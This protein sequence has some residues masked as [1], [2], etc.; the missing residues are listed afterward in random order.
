MR[1][2]LELTQALGYWGELGNS[3]IFPTL[4]LPHAFGDPLAPRLDLISRALGLCHKGQGWMVRRDALGYVGAVR[5]PEITDG[6]NGW[7]A[8]LHAL[9]FVQGAVS[10]SVV[11]SYRDWLYGRWGHVVASAG[12]GEINAYGL[13]VKVTGRDTG[14]IGE[15][16]QAVEG[17]WGMG[18]E[19][20]QAAAKYS[21]TPVD[22]LRLLAQTGDLS[23]RARWLEAEAATKGKSSIRYSKGLRALV[24]PEVEELS[25][26]EAASA[27]GLGR[28]LVKAWIERE[29]WVLLLKSGESGEALRELVEAAF[30]LVL[31]CELA[32]HVPAEVG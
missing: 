31:M 27:E 26:V 30:V 1:R 9:L 14:R 32:G 20:T 16:M 2:S 4:T 18:A 21:R 15:Y 12:F 6:P 23:G 25:D 3:V 11:D 22:S 29:E 28:W 17:G 10:D 8:H 13:D 7:H 24:L 5:A 19:L